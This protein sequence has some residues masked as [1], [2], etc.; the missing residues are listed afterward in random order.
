LRS[1]QSEAEWK[2][3]SSR[4]RSIVSVVFGDGKCEE[5]QLKH[6]KYWH[7]RQHTAKQRVI[8][9]AGKFQFFQG[10]W[11]AKKIYRRTPPG[12]GPICR[13]HLLSAVSANFLCVYKLHYQFCLF[14]RFT[15]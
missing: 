1:S 7:S 6:W 12:G 4:V 15:F 8:D 13:C 5:E 3:I 10:Y 9:I 14:F 11:W 2:G